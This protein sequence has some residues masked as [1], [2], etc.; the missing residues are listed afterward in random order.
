VAHFEDSTGVDRSLAYALLRLVLGINIAFHGISRI[1]TG[2]AAF[3]HTLLPLFAKT[4]LPAWSVYAFGLCLPW[5]EAL[6]GLLLIAGAASRVAY[7]LGLLQLAALTFG[8]SLRQDWASA[9]AQL[10]YALLYSILLATRGYN[11]YSVDGWLARRKSLQTKIV[12]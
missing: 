5:A 1:G 12:P 2:P 11:R 7:V 4:P 10:T 3:A 8:S 6:T 9:G